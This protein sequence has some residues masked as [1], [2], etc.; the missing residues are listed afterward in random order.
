LSDAK[1]PRGGSLTLGAYRLFGIAARPF[2]SGVLARRLKRGKED[3]DRIGERQGFAGTDRP[4]GPLIWLHAASNGEALSLLPLIELIAR[5]RADLTLLM[6]S[7]TVTSAELMATRLPRNALHQFVPLDHPA[8]CRRFLDHWKP[9]LGIWVESELWPNL[10][11]LAAKRGI[12]LALVNAR[13]SEKSLRNWRRFAPGLARRLLGS[14][15]LIVPQDGA[16]KARL[17]ALSGRAVADPQ[18]LKN[19]GAPLPATA[20]ALATL[21]Y[22]T[23]DRPLWLAAST[24]EGEEKIALDVH[25]RLKPRHQ[26]LLTVIVPRHPPRG[27][28][29]A[30][31]AETRGFSSVRRS[32]SAKL[33]DKTEIYVADTTG[34]LGTFFRIAQIVLVGGTLVPQGGHN[35]LEPARLA[36]ALIAGPSRFNFAETFA[37]F[38]AADAIDGVEDA[39]TLATAIDRLLS[40]DMLCDRRAEAARKVA[41]EASGAAEAVLLQ[42]KPLL[43]PA[44]GDESDAA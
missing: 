5:E 18:N 41:S 25:A 23:R 16:S 32:G 3:A 22:V 7:G 36:C 13:L 4:E 6:T 11:T 12:P 33:S 26:D 14:F 30:K 28:E 44:R 35:P 1:Q 39:D 8:Y 27:P 17:E 15:D 31:A 19:D 43:P 29:I 10:V 20:N 40:D 38:E 42:L 34:E 9:D 21:Q 2:L 37:L 24:H